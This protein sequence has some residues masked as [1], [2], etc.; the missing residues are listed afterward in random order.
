MK[1]F[2]IKNL[3]LA[4]KLGLIDWFEFLKQIRNMDDE[5]QDEQKNKTRSTLPGQNFKR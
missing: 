2:T 4:L 5:A 1:E 3:V